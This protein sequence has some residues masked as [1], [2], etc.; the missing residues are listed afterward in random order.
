[1]IRYRRGRGR[2]L[3]GIAAAA[4]LP[5]IA[6]AAEKADKGMPQLHVPD[7]APQLF[8]LAIWFVVLYVLMAKIGLPRIAV[9]IDARR[10]RRENDL[11]RAGD[12]KAQADQANATLQATM[13]QARA[14]AQA[15]LKQASD[16]LAAEAAARQRD[17]AERLT[18][19]IAAAERQIALT[20]EAALSEVR[21]IA[22]DVGRAAVE[23]LTGVPPDAARLATAV[24]HRL[25]GQPR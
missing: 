5:G 14:E 6:A 2:A 1:M 10:Q 22:I 4:L 23:K 11:A 19:Q 24:D 17:L 13:S 7:F 20:K 25:A 3:A 21:G 18:E 8:W 9:A 12:L 16:R 15:V